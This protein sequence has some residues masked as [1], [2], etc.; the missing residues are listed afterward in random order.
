MRAEEKPRELWGFCSL[1]KSVQKQL[2]VGSGL[3]AKLM[4]G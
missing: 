1:L 4:I 3:D 2:D